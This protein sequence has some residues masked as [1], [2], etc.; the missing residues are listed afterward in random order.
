MMRRKGRRYHSVL[1]WKNLH[2]APVTRPVGMA[3]I[4]DSRMRI[5]ITTRNTVNTAFT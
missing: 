5:T 2:S 4:H 3:G 1:S